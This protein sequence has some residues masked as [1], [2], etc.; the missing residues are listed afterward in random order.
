MTPRIPVSYGELIDRISILEIKVERLGAPEQRA[1]A[2]RELAMLLKTVAEMPEPP[3][4]LAAL[5]SALGKVNRRL[6]DIEDM[7]RQKE[8]SQS[9]DAEFIELARAVYRTND[10]RSR[11]KREINALLRSDIVDEK[12][13]TPY[14]Q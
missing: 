7:I 9:F 10:E 1:N 8:A 13:Y 14:R 11:I 12:Q 2:D 3:V 6:W 4:G 5:K